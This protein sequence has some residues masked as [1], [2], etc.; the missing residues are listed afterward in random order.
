ML[1]P[2]VV[3]LFEYWKLHPPAHMILG[4]VHLKQ[5]K[6]PMKRISEAESMAQLAE[7]S[8]IFGQGAEKLPSHLRNMAEW[9]LSEQNKL[10]TVVN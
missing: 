3:D 6:V 7:V 1:W 9:A 10:Q 8:A 2:D 5:S 4:A